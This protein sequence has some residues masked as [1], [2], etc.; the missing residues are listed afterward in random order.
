MIQKQTNNK[1]ILEEIDLKETILSE[2]QN[3]T[4]KIIE[5]EKK[6]CD[7][8][9]IYQELSLEIERQGE[10]VDSIESHIINTTKNVSES[11]ENFQEANKYTP[12]FGFFGRMYNVAKIVGKIF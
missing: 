4:E 8:H 6:I 9:D 10:T 5:I 3:R 1:Q 7:I 12:W 11:V 2:L